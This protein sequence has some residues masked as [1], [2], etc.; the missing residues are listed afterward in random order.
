MKA[1]YTERYVR[2]CERT[3]VSHRLLLD[4]YLYVEQFVHVG[5]PFV[6][7]GIEKIKYSELKKFI[8]ELI[9]KTKEENKNYEIDKLNRKK[10]LY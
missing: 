3:A 2:C 9:M 4:L 6:H 8:E 10:K 1:P 7:R 5:L